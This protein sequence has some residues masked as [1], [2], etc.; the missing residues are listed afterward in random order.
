MAT[1]RN[2][3]IDVHGYKLIL[4]PSH[5]ACRKNGFVL[6]HRLIAEK[7]IGRY[8]TG[9]EEVHHINHDK[10]DNR[11]ENLMVCADRT[12]HN[13]YDYGWRKDGEKWFK[14][15]PKCKVEK[16]VC[17]DNF[18]KRRGK[19][20]DAGEYGVYCIECECASNKSKYW[21]NPELSKEKSRAWSLA[22]P[23][24]VKERLL[25]YVETNR[26][27]IR[28]YQRNYHLQHKNVTN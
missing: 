22:N 8:L 15:C 1:K 12:E 21:E 13:K 17:S 16:E 14:L 7:M 5:P 27:K 20:K 3:Y 10:L 26:E 2:N 11:P 9:V 28:E 4:S 23:E 19:V 18:Y 24:R 6:E 25:R